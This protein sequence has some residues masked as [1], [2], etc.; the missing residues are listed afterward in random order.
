VGFVDDWHIKPTFH[1]NDDQKI[2]LTLSKNAARK[3]E[4]A[5]TL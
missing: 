2:R 5:K 4:E 1:I 3:Y